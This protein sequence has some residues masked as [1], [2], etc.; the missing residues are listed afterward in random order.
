MTS[1][2]DVLL[3]GPRGRRLCLELA[4]LLDPGV[5]EQAFCL[6]HELDTGSGTSRVMLT[7]VSSSGDAESQNGAQ[8]AVPSPEQLAARLGSLACSDLNSELVQAALERSVDSARYWQEPDGEDALA[9]L[10]AISAALVPVAE[11]LLAAPGSEWW[12]KPRRVEQWAIDWRTPNDATPLPENPR[13]TLAEW[14]RKAR[15]EEEQAVRER[16]EDPR[17]NVS[18]SWWSIPHGLVHTVGQVPAGLSL[19]EDSLGWEEATVIPVRGTGRTLEIRDAADWISLCRK[20]PLKV[21]ASRRHDWYRVIGRDGR[22]V[23]P[24]WE[25]IAGEWDAAHLTVLGYLNGAMRLLQ[26]DDENATVM[27]GWDPDST[28]WLTDVAHESEGGRQ[29]WHRP[30]QGEPWTRK[31]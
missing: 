22:W 24:D 13:R 1:R 7:A 21:T 20:Y 17:A 2:S 15:A 25:Q 14:A 31:P 6:G 5:R 18:G 8:H 12:G 29:T 23:I 3:S 9:G 28:L 27:A 4:M 26:V 10:P 19:V 30:F 16:P 11:Q